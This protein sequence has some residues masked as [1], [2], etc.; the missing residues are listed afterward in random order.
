MPSKTQSIL[1]AGVA[2]GVAA[3]LFSLIPMAGSCLA[4]I[5]YL[6]AGL[7]AVWHYTNTH[8]VTITGG[9]G[10]GIGALAGI[11][12]MIVASILGYLFMA[13][14]L[15]PNWQDMMMQQLE[16]SGM[17]PEQ[18]EQMAEFFSSPLVWVGF[19]L[20]GLVLYAIIGAIGGAI[21]ASVFKKGRDTFGESP[22]GI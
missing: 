8:Q 4:C 17:D 1:L 13:I 18:Q 16:A 14:G 10:A 11:V 22:A 21:G 20:L 2:I 15:A 3:A 9:Q 5:A 19:I 6:C 12:A 7:L